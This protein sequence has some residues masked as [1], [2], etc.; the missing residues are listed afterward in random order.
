MRHSNSLLQSSFKQEWRKLN[1]PLDWEDSE[2]EIITSDDR[3]YPSQEQETCVVWL[4]GE[5]V[6][7]F[8]SDSTEITKLRR[9]SAFR[10]DQLTL[11]NELRIIGVKGQLPKGNITLRTKGW[12]E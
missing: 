6:S 8:S 11:N 3:G 5:D 2:A 10:V 1:E 12:S 4:R 7:V 9:N